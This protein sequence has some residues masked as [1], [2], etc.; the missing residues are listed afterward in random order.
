[1]SNT[2]P[3]TLTLTLEDGTQLTGKSFGAHTDAAGEVVFNTGM[4]GYPESF[5]DPSYTGQILVLTYPLIGNYGVPSDE[6]DNHKIER[7]FESHNGITITGVV[8]SEYSNTHN[9]WQA[10]KSLGEWLKKNNIP[11]ISG[12][13]TRALTQ[14]IRTKGALLGTITKDPKTKMEFYDPNKEN[15]VAKVS[16][17]KPITYKGPKGSKHI[18]LVDCGMKL[19]ILRS[20]LNRGITVTRMPWNYNFWEEMTNT[21]FDGV[22]FSNGPGDP[23]VVTE[24]I[25]IMK[26]GFKRNVPT[27]GICL[28]SQ[29]MGIAAGGTTYKLKFGHR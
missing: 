28:G 6:T 29:I 22:F 20:F 26:E 1:M 13:D 4:V 23:A 25:E 24:T 27:F 18:A 9:H 17:D 21:K 12:I 10:V 11:G 15:L 5:S 3:K 14:K 7:F 8:V 19:N 16:V 2:D